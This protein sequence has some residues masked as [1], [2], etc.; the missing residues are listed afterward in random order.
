[1]QVTLLSKKPFRK[2]GRVFFAA[3]FYFFRVQQFLAPLAICPGRA[4]DVLPTAEPA[5][6]IPQVLFA[7]C[8]FFS[9]IIVVAPGNPV[10]HFNLII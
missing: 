3:L 9:G 10:I 5:A 4:R 6:L 1:M 8:D 2:S 7:I